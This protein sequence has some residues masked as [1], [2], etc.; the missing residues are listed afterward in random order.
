MLVTFYIDGSTTKILN[1]SKLNLEFLVS[2]A[3]LN[4]KLNSHREV[5]S[6]P[7]NPHPIR[8]TKMCRGVT[9]VDVEPG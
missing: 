4:F 6:Q 8:I 2:K 9:K 5:Y 7:P 3:S 1:K